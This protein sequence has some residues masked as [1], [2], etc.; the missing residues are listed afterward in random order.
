MQQV[1]F[2][3]DPRLRR[4]RKQRAT[5]R[6][7]DAGF[8]REAVATE[9]ADRLR[10]INRSFPA[11][12]CHGAPD[13]SQHVA[14]AALASDIVPGHPAT[15]CVFEESALPFAPASLDAYA[16][17]L[18]LHAVNDLPGAMLQVR[19]ALKPDGFFIAGF[20]G[21]G[22]LV[23]LRHALTVAEDEIMGGASPRI[24]PFTDVRDAGALLQRAGF[25]LPVADTDTLV[26]HY[27]NPFRLFEDLR[28]MGETSVLAERRRRFLRRDVLMRALEVWRQTASDGDGRLRATFEI[29][30]VAGWAPHDSQ[31]K[32]L[33]PGSARTPLAEALREVRERKS[34][35]TEG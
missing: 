12:V 8:L 18:T 26:V 32:P 2:I 6:A 29:L 4:R 1:P 28:H 10:A 21:A 13:V 16:S 20:F 11:F 35:E 5:G 31:Q 30:Y 3:F 22:T 27:A 23:E 34:G 17:I 19:R 25:A 14:T 15:R 24:A 7:G 33:R 9:I